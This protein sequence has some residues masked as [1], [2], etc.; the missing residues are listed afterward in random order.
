[1]LAR[2]HRSM[3]IQ[4]NWIHW[5]VLPGWPILPVRPILPGW[6]ILNRVPGTDPGKVKAC[7]RWIRVKGE[8]M[9]IKC[10]LEY[11]NVGASPICLVCLK[12]RQESITVNF[13]GSSYQCFFLSVLYDNWFV[14]F[15]CWNGSTP[16][17]PLQNQIW[18]IMYVSFCLVYFW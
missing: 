17:L 6:P 15:I 10:W 4:E 14:H 11:T 16:L 7:K 18:I 1:M 3:S 5:P 8:Y 13:F 9:I 12:A 2:C